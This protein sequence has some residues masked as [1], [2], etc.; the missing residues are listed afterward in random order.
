MRAEI[1]FQTWNLQM[2]LDMHMEVLGHLYLEFRT[3]V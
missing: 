3:E 1:P 2:F